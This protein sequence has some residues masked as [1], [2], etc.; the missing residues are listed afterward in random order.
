MH[1]L[2]YNI[3]LHQGEVFFQLVNM[4]DSM[5]QIGFYIFFILGKF[6]SVI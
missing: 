3:W 2:T 6:N 4:M 5:V 1:T